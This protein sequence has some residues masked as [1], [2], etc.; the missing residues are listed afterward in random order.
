MS[1]RGSLVGRLVA[2][3]AIW[4]A[5][6]LLVGV[7]GLAANYRARVYRDVDDSLRAS[8]RAIERNALLDEQGG[9]T[10]R[11][12]ERT[13][14]DAGGVTVWQRVSDDSRTNLAFGGRYWTV[15]RVDPEAGG[16]DTLAHSYSVYEGRITLD[17][18]LLRA[19]S[20]RPG[21]FV[22][23]YA[24]VEWPSGDGA[25]RAR[26]RSQAIALELE[27]GLEYVFAAGADNAPIR[28]GIA[29]F[30]L[31]SAALMAPLALV[32]VAG[33]FLQVRVG[34]E[35]VFR[36]RQDVAEIRE[37]DRDRLDGEIPS[38]LVPLAAELNALVDHNRDV[39]E[40]ARA[41]VGNLA[42]AL[43]TPIA[44]LLNESRTEEGPLAELTRR[45]AEI[46][47]S[48]VDHH[49]KRAS[50]AA[51]AKAIGARTP[52]AGVVD[53]LAR[54]LP[55]MYPDRPIDL[56]VA[57]PAELAFRGERQD[58][59]EMVGNLLDNAYKWARGRVRLEAEAAGA[60]RLT[61]AVSDDGPGLPEDKREE[62]LRRGARL[63]ETAPGSGL[64]LSIVN[65]L[66]RAYGGA[67]TLSAS[68]M[69]GLRAR[70][71][72]PASRAATRR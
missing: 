4:S 44:V 31:R 51:R 26:L 18:I 62:V 19:A 55:R 59:E 13:E 67:L 12:G 11:F 61:I 38:E 56:E 40:R 32:L 37:G 24:M 42:H 41:H 33:I 66:A 57:R 17:P 22:S 3:A 70:L 7:F 68:D 21:T 35:P 27:D 34:L 72:L 46:M 54:T 25:E 49:L 10:F 64:G 9:L 71:E 20:E 15:A 30:R 58:L 36:M 16:V 39:V 53:D 65:D 2:L 60:G 69:G 63:D 43:K 1:A 47:A 14:I 8:L 5:A 50:A 23:G 45:Q 28:A 6:L 29:T 48:Q 52:V